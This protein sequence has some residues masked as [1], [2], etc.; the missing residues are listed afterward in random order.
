[1]EEFCGQG[2]SLRNMFV[3]RELLCRTFTAPGI[4][5]QNIF[6]P[7]NPCAE[8]FHP[9]NPFAELFCPGNPFAE[10][11]RPGYPWAELYVCFAGNHPE[12]INS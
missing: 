4:P 7:R 2:F 5:R 6:H 8:L 10:L 12:S 11:F 3:H 1:M 9:G